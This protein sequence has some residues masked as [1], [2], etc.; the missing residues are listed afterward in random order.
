MSIVLNF[1]SIP[2][3]KEKLYAEV[4]TAAAGN[5]EVFSSNEYE[6]KVDVALV[7]G[8]SGA[9]QTDV[10]NAVNNHV[11]LHHEQPTAEDQNFLDE[12]QTLLGGSPTATDVLSAM[13]TWLQAKGLT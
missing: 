12:V 2:H 3:N 10:N 7:D 4:V 8:T 9:I 11:N 5:L 1:T 6:Q 13:E